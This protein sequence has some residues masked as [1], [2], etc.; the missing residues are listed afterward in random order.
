MM[1]ASSQAVPTT[2]ADPSTSVIAD[3]FASRLSPRVKPKA[4][5]RIGSINGA[6]IMAPI[7][8][9][10][11]LAISPRVAMTAEHSRRTKNPSEGLDEAMRA[12]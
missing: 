8:T 3:R 4:R 1:V 5:L 7:T 9:A 10:V 12:W 6:T 11:L 2:L